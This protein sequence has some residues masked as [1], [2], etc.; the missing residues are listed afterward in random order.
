M[1]HKARAFP[2]RWAVGPA[3]LLGTL[4]I[5]APG[6]LV[7]L[8][9]APAGRALETFQSLRDADH[10]FI[11]QPAAAITFDEL[12]G[13]APVRDQYPAAGVRFRHSA[14]GRYARLSRVHPEGGP[15]VEH[16][17]GYDGSYMPHGDHL[18]VKFDNHLAGTPLTILSDPPVSLVGAFVGMGVQGAVHSLTLTAF[19]AG[20]TEL[21]HFSLPA[22]IPEPGTIWLL[23]GGGLLVAALHRALRRPRLRSA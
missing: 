20:G 12:S 6:K 19:D 22:R 14:E 23:A 5:P 8:D 16:V 9:P 2:T 7:R 11:G 21:G 4:V 15:I 1:L 13:A 18:L 17:T 3:L 10:A